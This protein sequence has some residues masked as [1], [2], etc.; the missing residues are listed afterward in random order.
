M[1][2]PYLCPGTYPLQSGSSVGGYLHP[3]SY[4]Y[5][6]KVQILLIFGDFVYLLAHGVP[7]STNGYQVLNEE[8]LMCRVT[9]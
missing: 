2:H 4:K 7:I 9:E 3:Y 8:A 1:S 5:K 6:Y